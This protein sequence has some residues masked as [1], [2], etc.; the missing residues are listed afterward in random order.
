MSRLLDHLGRHP[1]RRPFDTLIAPLHRHHLRQSFTRAEVGQ[2]DDARVIHQ[3]VCALDVAVHDLVPVKVL[4]PQQN[5]PRVHAD[6]RLAEDHV[7]VLPVGPGFSEV[8]Q[9]EPVR[10]YQPGIK[11]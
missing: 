6:H 8:C 7:E 4:Q 2:L 3:D 9:L 1:I 11:H 5:L 10:F